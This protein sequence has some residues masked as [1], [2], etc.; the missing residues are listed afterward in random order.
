MLYCTDKPSNMK[1]GLYYTLNIP[2]YPLEIISM[3]FVGGL[4][5]TM[6]GH[7]Y[8]FMV[9]DRFKKMC[10]LMPCVID[11]FGSCDSKH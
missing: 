11:I 1:K 8:L 5:T 3:E 9:L 7:D 6:K 2:T 4:P 10:I